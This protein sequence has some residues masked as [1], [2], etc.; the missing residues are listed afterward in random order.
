MYVM[1]SVDALPPSSS[2]LGSLAMSGEASGTASV[3]D[4][5]READNRIITSGLNEAIG[6]ATEQ[7][8]LR[9]VDRV[10]TAFEVGAL[11]FDGDRA[12]FQRTKSQNAS[13]A[14]GL[15]EYRVGIKKKPSLV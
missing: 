1:C 3:Q 2:R 12:W 5:L 10:I 15:S 6:T 14:D 4:Q 7:Y 8:K 9:Q 11:F 13:R